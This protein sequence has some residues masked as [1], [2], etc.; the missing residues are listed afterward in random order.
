MQAISPFHARSR[1]EKIYRLLDRRVSAVETLIA[2][3][4]DQ[5]QA[6]ILD[7]NAW[8]LDEIPGPDVTD[9]G[10]VLSLAKMTLDA[11]IQ[12]PFTHDWKDV[13][14]GFN[15]SQSFGWEEDGLRGHIFADADNS[16]I[17][18]AIK[19]TTAGN[20]D[21]CTSIYVAL[22]TLLQRFSMVRR[23]PLMTRLT[24]I[25]S[26]AAVAHNKEVFCGGK[27]A[28]ANQAPS[29]V[30]KHVWKENC[31]GRTGII[32]LPLTS[33]VTQQNYTQ[34]PMFGLLDILLEGRLV[35]WLD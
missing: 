8:S 14:E 26:S 31:D 27:C 15:Y 34:I 6:Q 3:A 28:A 20:S 19:G 21:S 23:L 25:C 11:Y 16:T 12:E 24:T 5:G 33:I 30:I 7:V 29:L 18:I 17:V 4:R 9:K 35:A 10:T 1:P 22:L 2:A 32:E 13:K